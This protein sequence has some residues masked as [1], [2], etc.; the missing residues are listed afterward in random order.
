VYKNQIH[1]E[2]N[3][4]MTEGIC[5]WFFVVPVGKK[6]MEN[7]PASASGSRGSGGI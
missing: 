5:Q 7:P 6:G 1:Y 2:I 4:A 3:I